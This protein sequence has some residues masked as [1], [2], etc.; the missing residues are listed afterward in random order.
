MKFLAFL[1]CLQTIVSSQVQP[2]DSTRKYEII[3]SIFE[4]YFDNVLNNSL[5][6]VSS[7]DRYKNNF[8]SFQDDVLKNRNAICDVDN[9][10]FTDLGDKKSQISKW[11]NQ[12]NKN[13]VVPELLDYFNQ[14][15]LSSDS[16]IEL[17][18]NKK[19]YQKDFQNLV[20]IISVQ[21]SNKGCDMCFKKRHSSTSVT[22]LET[23]GY[24]ILFVGLIS[25][26]SLCGA[27]VIPF[28][29]KKIYKKILML[30]IGVAIGSLA[31][32]GFLHLIPQAYGITED[33]KY[34]GNHAY[35]WK[36]LVIMFGIYLFYLVEKFMKIMFQ[37][38]NTL[39][40]NS[41]SIK[42]SRNKSDKENPVILESIGYLKTHDPKHDP[43]IEM[44]HHLSQEALANYQNKDRKKNHGHSHGLEN[45]TSVAPVAWMIIFGDGLHNFIDGLSIGAAFTESV[46]KGISIC[47]AVMCEEFPHEL[48]DFAI[49]INA[50]MSYPMALF[51]NFLSACSCFIG[52]IVGIQ[53]G[54]NFGANEWIYAIAGG[55]F[56]YISLCGMI[57]EMNEIGEEIEKDYL[58]EKYSILNDECKTFSD[59][60]AKKGDHSN[61]TSQ[62]FDL[63]IKIKVLVI[64]NVGILFGFAFMLF[65]AMYS[66]LI[67]V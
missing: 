19:S 20:K 24:G 47:L 21:Q 46:F 5:A 17:F 16:L 60:Q 59:N 30:L 67:T 45:L 65:M 53:L 52:L 63:S 25:L 58:S 49:L 61:D 50:G 56:I 28:S 43:N 38:R 51:F 44:R 66:E 35:V 57:P 48:G 15:C 11:L 37:R 1:F 31:G 2:G 39:K 22:K 26:S 4:L 41:Y 13:N 29:N 54:E 6:D 8:K 18:V 64:Q 10:K 33:E 32:S 14:T 12:S 55:M 62:I 42:Q 40:K 23:W 27:I 34:S 7:F 36:S 9:V 3:N